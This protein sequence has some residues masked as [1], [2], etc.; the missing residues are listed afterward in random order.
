M[1][2]TIAV[3]GLGLFG[4]AVARTLAKS[5]VDVIAIDKNMDHVEEVLDCVN[6][7]VQADFTKI[8]QL[9]AL[10]V[11]NAD[12]AIVATGEKLEVAILAIMN[13]RKLGIPEVIVKTKNVEY[14]EVLLKVGA[15]RVV[16]P[17]IEMGIRLGNELSDKSVLDAIQMDEKYHLV[18]L[19]VSEDWVGKQ[20]VDMDF[21]NKHEFNIIAIRSKGN[22][23]FD[24]Q[25][26]PNYR[27]QAG[28]IFLVFS[29]NDT[30]N[31][32]L[33]G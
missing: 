10:G 22:K 26:D 15:T 7:A 13:L 17:E 20:I 23:N 27:I 14:K 29:E 21:R 24:A 32:S 9:K 4:S 18:E 19:H 16:L 31:H 3:L 1:N 30:I 6:Y 28:D 5:G 11:D 8:E 25:V 33:E 12:V 2:K